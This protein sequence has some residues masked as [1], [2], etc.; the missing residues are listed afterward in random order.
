LVI[1]EVDLM[2]SSARTLREIA[3]EVPNA[4]PLLEEL[5]LD[6]C[7]RGTLSLEQACTEAGLDPG[8]VV[9]RLRA[10][11]QQIAS[12]EPAETRFQTARALI[13][14]IL[15]KHHR[16]A[17]DAMASLGQLMSKVLRVH[18]P[19]HPELAELAQTFREVVAELEPHQVREEAV[20]F[21][22]ILALEEGGPVL[23]PM[24]VTHPVARMTQD[25][26]VMGELLR[27]LA[28]QTHDYTPPAEACASWCALYTGL[29]AFERDLHLHIHLE[30]NV[31]F[32][33]AI[34][35]AGR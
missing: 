31:L 28:A 5:H 10:I 9:G 11:E 1:L 29:A 25:H 15:E 6:Y 32:P 18:A 4:I 8:V 3:T 30:N 2:L 26:E 19:R 35:L 17:R 23:L 27:R 14:H 13:E 21:P 34:A 12:E 33:R 20:L 22:A 24:P 16:Y 7:C